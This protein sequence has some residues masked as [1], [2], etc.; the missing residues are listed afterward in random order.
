MCYNIDMRNNNVKTDFVTTLP[1]SL[2][3]LYDL[4]A[5]QEHY[6]FG[7]KTLTE[8][9]D[10][11]PDL[12]SVETHDASI[13]YAVLG[14]KD[15]RLDND[16]PLLAI[17]MPFANG[18]TPGKYILAE[19]TRR[20]AAPDHRVIAFPSPRAGQL[21]NIIL[22]GLKADQ[23]ASGILDP[24]AELQA[25]VLLDYSVGEVAFVGYS[26]GAMTMTYAAE[27]TKSKLD[28][29][30]VVSVEDPGLVEGRTEKE[31]QKAFA[32]DGIDG[33][34]DLFAAVR[35]SGIPALQEAQG[36]GSSNIPKWPMIKDFVGLGVSQSSRANRALKSAMTKGTS[37][38]ALERLQLSG[39]DI[40]IA[41][42]LESKILTAEA[43]AAIQQKLGETARYISIEGYGHEAADNV[44][45]FSLIVK[46]ALKGI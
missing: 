33:L 14:D 21:D 2:E 15:G 45:A 32:G 38:R 12:Q 31:L 39:A 26:Q 19:M 41:R 20:I 6:E 28:S 9:I 34:K 18:W 5:M 46:Q 1:Y 37:A 44:T 29:V 7:K 3:P 27:Y 35:D 4:D 36:V 13:R 22:R 43:F 25:R 30:Q 10:D 16:S 24:L 17:A 11:M 42:A 8:I 40:T 23:V